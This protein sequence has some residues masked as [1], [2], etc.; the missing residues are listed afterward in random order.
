MTDHP[1]PRREPW[2]S[3]ELE[4]YRNARNDDE[5]RRMLLCFGVDEAHRS[6]AERLFHPP[7]PEPEPP[8]PAERIEL[9]LR[10]QTKAMQEQMERYHSEFKSYREAQDVQHRKD[11]LEQ[12]IV[13]I[14]AGAI[15]SVVGG[16]VLLAIDHWSEISAFVSKFFQ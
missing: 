3:S 8:T 5:R 9:E 4:D 16:L 1:R 11:K 14:I 7:E 12:W 2:I 13:A 15:A 6:E 10:Q